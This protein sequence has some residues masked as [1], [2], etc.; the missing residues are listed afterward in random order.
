M[1]VSCGLSFDESDTR[2]IPSCGGYQE[3]NSKHDAEVAK[4]GPQGLPTPF[5]FQ[6]LAFE[7]TGAM[8]RETEKWWKSVVAM[9]AERRG[10]DQPS[11]RRDLGLEHTWA[12]HSFSAYWRQSIATTL[13]KSQAEA[14]VS[15]IKRSCD[16][17]PE[18][19]D[20]TY[21]ECTV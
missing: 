8:S 16:S 15:C 19:T 20:S 12:A 4:A 14:I 10:A 21:D 13:A 9:E 3:K 11:S 7:T 17:H 6:P 5:E 2:L 18:S 1:H